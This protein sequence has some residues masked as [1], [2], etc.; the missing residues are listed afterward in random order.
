MKII[1]YIIRMLNGLVIL[2]KRGAFRKGIE[3]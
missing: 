2:K 3:R 1:W